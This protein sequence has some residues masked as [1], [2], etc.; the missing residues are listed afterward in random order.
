MKRRTSQPNKLHRLHTSHRHLSPYN[1]LLPHNSDYRFRDR[2]IDHYI[3]SA[4]L[5][6]KRRTSQPNKL[7]RLHTSHR[8]L[9]PYNRLLPH[10]SDYRFRG[11]C[12]GHYIKSAHLSTMYHTIQ[13]NRLC[14]F[15]IFRLHLH[16]YNRP[17]HHNTHY[18]TTGRHS[19]Y[20][21]THNRLNTMYC[22]SHSNKHHHSRISCL[23]LHLCNYPTH[24]NSDCQTQ[25][26]C[27]DHCTIFDH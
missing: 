5:S 9:S 26:Q 18:P 1:R 27:T 23:H 7:H 12:I 14:R 20:C 10:N 2:C 25:D 4:H 16:H 24:H 6:M 3:K 11:R 22:T 19:D 8:H 21:T 17:M 15:R 13:P